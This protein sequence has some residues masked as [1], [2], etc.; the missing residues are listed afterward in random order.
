MESDSFAIKM[1]LLGDLAFTCA[2]QAHQGQAA[3]NCSY[4]S[5][6]EKPR[7]SE[8]HKDGSPHNVR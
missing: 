7:L 4:F 1:L 3:W 2:F 6:S 5:Y 8:A